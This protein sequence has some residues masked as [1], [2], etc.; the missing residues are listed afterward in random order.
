MVLSAHSGK[1]AW[2]GADLQDAVA[3]LHGQGLLHKAVQLDVALVENASGEET[4]KQIG[5]LACLLGEE[6]GIGHVSKTCS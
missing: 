4:A 3:C 1:H 2:A 5:G 6:I